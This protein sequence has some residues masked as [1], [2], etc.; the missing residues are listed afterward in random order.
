MPQ[1]RRWDHRYLVEHRLKHV[2]LLMIM[3]RDVTSVDGVNTSISY[4]ILG[5]WISAYG[6]LKNGMA[7]M[8]GNGYRWWW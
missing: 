5:W 3:L 6:R 8:D 7:Y 2:G 4:A 1:L